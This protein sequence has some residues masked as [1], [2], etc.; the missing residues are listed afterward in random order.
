MKVY[1]ISFKNIMSGLEGDF[2]DF[3]L[4]FKIKKSSE[5]LNL[6]LTNIEE[7]IA[8]FVCKI[9]DLED[10][11]FILHIEFQ[12]TNNKEMHFRM[13]RYLIELHKLHNLPIIQ[14]VLYFGKN[15]LNMQDNIKFE[16]YDTKIVYQYKLI[17]INELDYKDFINSDNPNLVLLSILCNLENKNKREVIKKIK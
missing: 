7:K 3:F 4:G 13:L 17:D 2:T 11:D 16:I 8:D 14:L 15:K 1:D 9:T 5:A 12:T 10:K 6:E